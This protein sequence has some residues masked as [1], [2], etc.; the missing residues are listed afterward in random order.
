[1][2]HVDAGTAH[3]AEDKEPAV[4][5]LRY[6]QRVAGLQHDVGLH[7][8]ANEKIVQGQGL[9]L[10][11]G[12]HQTGLG[13]RSIFGESSGS[14]QGLENG[15]AGPQRIDARPHYL[16]QHRDTDL[17]KLLDYNRNLRIA[18]VEAVGAHELAGQ[19]VD[20]EP[21]G[22]DGP[23]KRERDG[24]IREDGDNP[25]EV[26]LTIDGDFDN[27][28]G[29]KNVGLLGG[30]GWGDEHQHDGE[31]EEHSRSHRITS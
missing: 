24:P 13:D 9:V 27:V 4:E 1:A 14:G 2:E 19:V 23:N 20:R 18:N 22:N 6:Q 29:S 21:A 30:D 17:A 28:F 8:L 10:P 3:I 7:V 25:G 5:F 26:G 16:A 15:G 31:A 11:G 12:A